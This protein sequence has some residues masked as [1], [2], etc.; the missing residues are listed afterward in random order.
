MVMGL[1]LAGTDTT[2]HQLGLGML[3]FARNPDQWERIAASPDSVVAATEEVVRFDP[4]ASGTLRIATEDVTHRGV[5]FP[6][7]SSVYLL[8]TA[9]TATP[10][11]WR[12]RTS[13]T[14][15]PTVAPSR[16]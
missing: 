4:T 6:A 3:W 5:T 1:L 10:S 16:R 9:A 15:P 12:A 13:S 7:G 11:W 2:R 14:P 8:S